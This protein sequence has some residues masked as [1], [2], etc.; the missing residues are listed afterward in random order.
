MAIPKDGP[1]DCQSEWS[2]SDWERR[3]IQHIQL[4]TIYTIIILLIKGILKNMIQ[5]KLFTKQKQTQREWIYGYQGGMWCRVAKD[6]S[7]V[8]G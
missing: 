6:S 5:I 2:K 3:I 8:W 1:T 4:Y 7:G